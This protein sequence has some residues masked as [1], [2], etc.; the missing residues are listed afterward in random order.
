[1]RN[2]LARRPL[3]QA[4]RGALWSRRDRFWLRALWRKVHDLLLELGRAEDRLRKLDAKRKGR[5]K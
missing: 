4:Q 5:K 2:K 1:M 3:T